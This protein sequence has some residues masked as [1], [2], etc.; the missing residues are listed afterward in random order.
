MAPPPLGCLRL[1]RPKA[2]IQ[3]RPKHGPQE[4]IKSRGK[5]LLI[6]LL[7]SQVLELLHANTKKWGLHTGSH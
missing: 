1:G 7:A 5:Q 6:L 2:D 4:M 3:T